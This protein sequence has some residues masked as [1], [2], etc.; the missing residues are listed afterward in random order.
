M[1]ARPR[2]EIV[3]ILEPSK[4]R[5]AGHLPTDATSFY[6]REVPVLSAFTGVH[7]DY[8]APSDTA[9]KLNYDGAA[10]IASLL[11]RAAWRL[12]EDVERPAYIRMAPPAASGGG[13]GGL[14]LG[15]IPDY[16]QGEVKG[17]RLSGVSPG[18]PAEEAGL[19]G[20][21]IIIELAGERVED[22]YAYMAVMNKLTPDQ[23]AQIAVRRKGERV[24][25]GIV[26][27]KR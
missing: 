26:P 7:T 27:R 19:K 3:R 24:E 25:L 20:G 12:T 6:L 1:I 9:D 23:K 8:H 17:V 5:I 16:T 22:I 11:A 18:G 13:R 10:A 4:R 15:T 14:Y 2:R 21:D